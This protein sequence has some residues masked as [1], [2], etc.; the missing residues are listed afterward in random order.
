MSCHVMTMAY[1]NLLHAYG[2]MAITYVMLYVYIM[3]WNLSTAT[4]RENLYWCMTSSVGVCM[5]ES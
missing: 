2:A 4:S 5:R 1:D 3:L